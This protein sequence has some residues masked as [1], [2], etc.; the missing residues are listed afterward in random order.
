[1]NDGR[2]LGVGFALAV[3]LGISV[4]VLAFLFAPPIHF[5][6]QW[7]WLDAWGQLGVTL[8]AGWAAFVLTM[9]LTVFALVAKGFADHDRRSSL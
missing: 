6:G 3:V 7:S 1:M 9:V 5:P 4:G 2:L 8:A